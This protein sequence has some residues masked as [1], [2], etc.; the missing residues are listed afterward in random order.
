MEIDSQRPE[1]REGGILALN[2][3]VE[4]MNLAEKTSSTALP[5][6]VF[7]SVSILLTLI[8]V[9]F[10]LFYNG[11]PQIYTQPRTQRLMNRIM[12]NLGCSA[13]ISVEDLNE[14]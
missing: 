8:R 13:P 11:L 6:T 3:A 5:K 7:G 4:A 10:P 1:G 2:A 9:C 14:G 12:S